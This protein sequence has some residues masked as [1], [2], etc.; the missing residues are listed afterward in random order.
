MAALHAPVLADFAHDVTVVATSPVRADPLAGSFGMASWT[1]GLDEALATLPAPD[2]AI[3]VLPVDQLATATLALLRAGVRRVLIEK[4]ACLWH[5][6]LAPVVA[7]AEQRDAFVAVAYNRRFFAS[8]IEARRRIDDAGGVLS[9]SFEFTEN[10]PRVAELATPA[11]IKAR[12][13]LANS[14]HVIDLA[15]HL[16][17]WPSDWATR[18]TGALSWHPAGADFRGM[19]ATDRGASFS[20]FADWRGPGRWGVELVLPNER[21]VLRPMEQL[22]VMPLGRFDLQP[23]EIADQLDRAFKPGLYRQMQAFLAET[24]AP[25]LVTV[26]QQLRAVRD[27]YDRIA[28]GKEKS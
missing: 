4:P 5:D 25:E 24:P 18:T 23:V 8:V 10:A 19:G 22:A 28:C 27:V 3:V 15:F 12:W 20:Y 17:G 16:G 1:R 2:A 13:L 21:L 6:E 14:S 9:F 26:A 11:Q 7:E